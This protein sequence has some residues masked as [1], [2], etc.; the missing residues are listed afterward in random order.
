VTWI[1]LLRSG[2]RPDDTTCYGPFPDQQ[3][4]ERFAAYLTVEVDPAIASPLQS[5]VRELLAWYDNQ[6]GSY[7]PIEQA[8][9]DH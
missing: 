3:T 5:P 8:S 9:H 6:P 7:I 1:V 2:S 4:A